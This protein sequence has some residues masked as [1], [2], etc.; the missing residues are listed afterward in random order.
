VLE[1][2]DDIDWDSE[3]DLEGEASA[4]PDLIR[5]LLAP[6][7]EAR[8]EALAELHQRLCHQES[9]SP[10]CARVVPFL[11]EIAGSPRARDRRHVLALLNTIGW[12]AL[13]SPRPDRRTLQAVGAGAR[14]YLQLLEHP[15][16]ATIGV[17]AGVLLGLCRARSAE[18]LPTLRRVCS[19]RGRHPELRASAAMAISEMAGPDEVALL[20]ESF[21]AGPR[22]NAVFRLA[23]VLALAWA[24]PAHLPDAALAE[25]LDWFR[26]HRELTQVT[27]EF[28]WADAITP[29]AVLRGVAAADPTRLLGPLSQLA[30]TAGPDGARWLVDAL[31]AAALPAVPAGWSP[32]AGP[33]VAPRAASSLSAREREVLTLIARRPSLW[34]PGGHRELELE[35]YG[36]P[37]DRHQ[38]LSFLELPVDGEALGAEEVDDGHQAGDPGAEEPDAEEPDAEEPDSEEPEAGQPE[39]EPPLWL[40]PLAVVVLALLLRL[41]R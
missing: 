30:E 18:V 26:R 28:P 40:V 20:R 31:L 8:E 19:D 37:S 25:L 23:S 11:I 9:I 22:G 33:R 34:G 41:C 3:V 21:A 24:D 6:S 13:T 38:L 10:V 4:L 7:R 39:R 14:T 12:G 35:G 27:G 15:D 2:L 17:Q 29:A 16:A 36:L 5:Q 32:Q 1:G